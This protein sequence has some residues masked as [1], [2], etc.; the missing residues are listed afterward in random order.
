MGIGLSDKN[1]DQPIGFVLI[2]PV[3]RIRRYSNGPQSLLFY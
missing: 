1:G 2:R 3:G